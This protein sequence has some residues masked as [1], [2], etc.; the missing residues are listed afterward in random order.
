MYDVLDLPIS[1]VPAPEDTEERTPS[2][3]FQTGKESPISHFLSKPYRFP[4]PGVDRGIVRLMVRAQTD[5]HVVNIRETVT[6]EGTEAAGA[7][8]ATRGERDIPKIVHLIDGFMQR[9]GKVISRRATKIMAQ[10]FGTR[11]GI[12]ICEDSSALVL[13]YR[14]AAPDTRVEGRPLLSQTTC[15]LLPASQRFT[16]VCVDERSGR[17]P[18]SAVIELNNYNL[19]R[20]HTYSKQIIKARILGIK[21]TYT[22]HEFKLQILISS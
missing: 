13:R 12:V 22:H 8:A 4:V 9:N 10:F 6:V 3:L 15:F 19:F 7:G 20:R 17:V 1:K 16:K 11:M 21:N 5:L 2:A 14:S 18:R